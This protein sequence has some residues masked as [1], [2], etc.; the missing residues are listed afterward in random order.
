MRYGNDD[1]LTQIG[2]PLQQKS[3]Q[4]IPEANTETETEKE[5]NKIETELKSHVM[6]LQFQNQK[7]CDVFELLLNNRKG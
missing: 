2:C 1:I 3:K 6:P 7:R 5:L 4:F